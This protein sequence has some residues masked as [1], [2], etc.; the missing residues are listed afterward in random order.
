MGRAFGR[1]FSSARIHGAV[2]FVRRLMTILSPESS[3]R[4]D[5]SIIHAGAE[6]PQPASGEGPMGGLRLCLTQGPAGFSAVDSPRECMRGRP[7]GRSSGHRALGRSVWFLPSGNA[8]VREAGSIAMA[9]R[10]SYSLEL[11]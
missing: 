1:R 9:N 8:L 7:L 3:T 10:R 6:L 11:S 4:S 5:F 2:A